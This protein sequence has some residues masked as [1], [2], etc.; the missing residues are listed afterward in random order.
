MLPLRLLFPGKYLANI[1][2]DINTDISNLRTIVPEPDVNFFYNGYFMLESKTFSFYNLSE[3]DV[4]YVVPLNLGTSLSNTK[5]GKAEYEANI[6]KL[7]SNI[8]SIVTS[9]ITDYLSLVS[10]VSPSASTRVQLMADEM[11]D[12]LQKILPIPGIQKEIARIEDLECSKLELRQKSFRKMVSR[13]S[14]IRNSL[15]ETKRNIASMLS[16]NR[17]NNLGDSMVT[18]LGEQVTQPCDDPLPILY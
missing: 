3:K 7:N 4:I 10:L 16:L 17:N 14:N 13:H 1:E 6:N 8:S 15:N 5:Q 9:S 2:V 18:V 11:K 12:T